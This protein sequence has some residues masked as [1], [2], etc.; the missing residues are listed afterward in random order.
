MLD[1]NSLTEKCRAALVAAQELAQNHQHPQVEPI[2]LA[3][4][5]FADADGLARRLAE[6]C[7]ADGAALE[8]Q[9]RRGLA[10]IPS[11]TP[12]PAQVNLSNDFARVL[13]AAQKDQKNRGDTHLAID[14]LVVALADDRRVAPIYQRAKLSRAALAQAVDEVR[15]G[16]T[17]QSDQAEN[18]YDALAKY[19]RDLVADARKGKLD[20]VIGRDE[21]IRRT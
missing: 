1:P 5:L 14:H 20:P 9:L 4:A 13:T 18:A 7:G 19:G 16:R 6:K 8:T 3:T 11:Q 21:E 12:P 10:E 17:V 15:K 2:H